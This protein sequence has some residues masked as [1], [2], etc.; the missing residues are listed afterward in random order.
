MMKVMV[1]SMMVVVQP[2]MVMKS[3]MMM[4]HTSHWARVPMKAQTQNLG[5]G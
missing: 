2:M 5:P 3:T 4:E 1:Q